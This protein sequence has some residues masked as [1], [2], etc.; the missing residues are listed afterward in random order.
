MGITEEKLSYLQ[1]TKN[2]IKQ[3]IE[4]KGINVSD[5]DT[6]RSYAMKINNINSENGEGS[7]INIVDNLESDDASSALSAKQGKELNLK[8]TNLN[9]NKLDKTGGIING[10]IEYKSKNLQDVDFNNYTMSG[11]FYMGTGCS[12]SP[13]G[14][15][16]VRLYVNGDGGPGTAQLA[17]PVTTNDLYIRT[18]VNGVWDNWKMAN[19]SDR[20][21]ASSNFNNMKIPG[22]YSYGGQDYTNKPAGFGLIE[23]NKS[24]SYIV[25]KRINSNSIAIRTSWDNGENW[26]PWSYYD[27][28]SVKTYSYTNTNIKN[29]S[30]YFYKCG[31]IVYFTCEGDITNLSSGGFTT[32]ING[33]DEQLTPVNDK[34]TCAPYNTNEYYLL[35]I[36]GNSVFLANYA[37]AITQAHNGA[38]IGCYIAKV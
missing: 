10:E 33:I 34:F 3:A 6:F 25:Q 15:N 20:G 2:E 1:E 35:M 17:I 7:S 13:D 29:G 30:I 9:N 32:Y 24:N 5:N 38:F 28:R 37:N 22:M 26:N 11:N 14:Q 27:D 4:S 8:I 12:N 18:A 31:R 23:V 16:W 36:N 21:Y 19:F